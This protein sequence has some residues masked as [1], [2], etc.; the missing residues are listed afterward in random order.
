MHSFIPDLQINTVSIYVCENHTVIEISMRKRTKIKVHISCVVVT[1]YMDI[2]CSLSASSIPICE[3]FCHVLWIHNMVYGL[4]EWK[5][6][7]K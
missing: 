7:I 1:N 3:I 5:H 6:C 4:P 2:F